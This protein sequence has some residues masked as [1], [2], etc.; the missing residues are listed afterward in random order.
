MI[1]KRRETDIH[2]LPHRKEIRRELRSSL[3]P[4]EAAL[5]KIL[6]GSW[7]DGRK[8][9]RQHSVGPFVLDFYCPS[10][11][12]AIE[13]DGQIHFSGKAREYDTARRVYLESK[14]ITVVRIENKFVFDDPE[15]VV[16]LI[17]GTFQPDE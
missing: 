16:D 3:T 11:K 2:N 6:K 14:G 17:R 12:L 10:E 9:R 1:Y 5:W 13:L 8:F 7:L 4:A 15:W